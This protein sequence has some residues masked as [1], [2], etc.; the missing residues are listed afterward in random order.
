MAAKSVFSVTPVQSFDKYKILKHDKY[1]LANE[2][3]YDMRDAYHKLK[4]DREMVTEE[5]IM[6]H[7]KNEGHAIVD[8][9]GFCISILWHVLTDSEFNVVYELHPLK[10][11]DGKFIL[12]QWGDACFDI[13]IYNAT[14]ARIKLNDEDGFLYMK[15]V[16]NHFTLPDF[17]L[18]NPLFYI[19]WIKIET[20]GDSA[21]CKMIFMDPTSFT[22]FKQMSD[23]FYVNFMP[24]I[25]KVLTSCLQL[26]DMQ[27]TSLIDTS[28]I[29]SKL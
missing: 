28:D 6:K 4:I 22:K 25:G 3:Y 29:H 26:F 2:K 15:R 12:P 5:R 23:F 1:P 19:G 13:R 18:D 17:T 7:P 16:G 20:D 24:S 21:D 9:N 11:I 14:Y 27:D 8:Y 10:K